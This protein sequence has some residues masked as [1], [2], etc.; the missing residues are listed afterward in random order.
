MCACAPK[1]YSH[2]SIKDVFAKEYSLVAK[3]MRENYKH[4]TTIW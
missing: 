4:Y 2:M 1:D 3:A